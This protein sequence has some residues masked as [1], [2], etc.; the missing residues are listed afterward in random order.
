MT[1][2]SCYICSQ[3][4]NSAGERIRLFDNV[5]DVSFYWNFYVITHVDKGC[6]LINVD[7]KFFL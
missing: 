2:G 5:F 4:D 6:I 7:S 3:T 1:F